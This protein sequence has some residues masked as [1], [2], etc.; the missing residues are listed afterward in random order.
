MCPAG[1]DHAEN[2][3]S[4]ESLTDGS[5]IHVGFADLKNARRWLGFPELAQADLPV[6]LEM[7]EKYAASP[8]TAVRTL[9]R[10]IEAH[11][12]ARQRLTGDPR[13][14]ATLIRLLGASEA[15]GEFLIRNPEHLD[16]ADE[17][18]QAEPQDIPAEQLRQDLLDSVGAQATDHL[19]VATVTGDDAY[20][21]LRVAY[22]RGLTR[23]ALRDL[24]A[25]SPVDQVPA[26][27]RQ[28]ADLAAAAIDAALSVSRAELLE[29]ADEQD[30][31]LLPRVSLAV[32]G[33]GK[34]GARELNYISDVDVIHVHELLDQ[35]PTTVA[36]IEAA[37]EAEADTEAT[38]TDMDQRVARSSTASPRGSVAN[39]L[40]DEERAAVL[41]AKLASGTA[42]AIMTSSSEPPLWELD[43]NL[44][45]EGKDGPL[46]R[47]VDS[48]VRYYK[49]WAKSWEFQALLKARPMAGDRE[50]GRR[51]AEAITPFVWESS[52]REGFV[53]S[54]QA[55][56]SRVTD[57]IPSEERERQI[58][59]GPGGLRDVEFT[60]QL[61]QL[62]HGRSD[63]RV[64]TQATTVSLHALSDHG[65][66]ARKD[67]EQFGQHYRWLRLLEHRIQLFRLRRTHLMPTRKP[68][69]NV[70]AVAMQPPEP[71]TRANGDAL[72]EQW[73]KV[74]RQVKGMH[75]KMFYRPLLAALS[76]TPLDGVALSDEQVRDRLTVLGY[77]DARAAQRH[78][79]ALTK[80][81]SR[82]AEILRT[83]LPVLLEWLGQ[84]VD[85]DAGLL[86]FRR[87]SEALGSSPWYLRMLRD[88]NMA[89]ERLCQIVSSSRYITDSLENQPEAVAWLGR[90]AE[91]E[92]HEFAHLWEEIQAQ[93]DRHRGADEAIRMIRVLRRREVLRVALADAC[94]LLD[95]DRV[96]AALSD[97]DRATVLGALHVAERE[98]YIREEQGCLAD[99]LVVA[100]GR[101]GGREIGYGS[102]ADVMF[103][104]MPC[105]GEHSHGHPEMDHGPVPAGQEA[106]AAD[107][108]ERT[109]QQCAADQAQSVVQRLIQLL[110]APCTPVIV[111]ERY[112]EID[113]D[114]RPEGKQGAM[115]RSVDSYREYY[116]RWAE[117]W[118]FQA[119]TRALPMAGSDAVA[120]HFLEVI[121]PHRYPAEFSD[122][123]LQ[124]IR[125]MKAR[126]ENER[127]PRGADP[128]RHLKLGRGSLSDVEWL[129][130]TLQ[131]QHAHD[132][133]SLRTTST[134]RTLQAAVEE[135]LLEEADAQALSRAWRL[136][137]QI[138]NYNVLRT[139]RSSDVLP[140]A[141]LDMEAVAR[142]CGYPSGH[143]EALEDDYLKITRHA[144]SVFERVFYGR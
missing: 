53:E 89:A 79:E 22:R 67:A 43:A 58:K 23:I 98:L 69:L 119:L 27:G 50:L 9:V 133:P 29:S 82:R 87:I 73:R 48:H 26:V 65:Y 31:D 15:L 103:A 71:V 36:Q 64:R 136:C 1:P 125:R 115:V 75:E 10:L 106:V 24:G 112:L 129:A 66:I 132:H 123:Q 51:Y 68:E 91:L 127:L 19:P 30:S 86:G 34:C 122:R 135:N 137:T 47:T 12:R 61:M 42:R 33:M 55:M 144:R 38:G 101:Q 18:L 60:V 121:D 102:D 124:D 107:D 70:I 130:Q 131:L 54:V 85:A 2:N 21:A 72:V 7:L 77:R 13:S 37:A 5:L 41:A 92:P 126:V 76:H 59:L 110:K 94:G 83:L 40:D 32:I 100:M 93:M 108:S 56:R 97:V 11:P 74:Q 96:V 52:Q 46:S 6:L 81:V 143:A 80:G 62:V 114:L 139:G 84:G 44:R 4:V 138:R 90:D 140:K 88:S 3:T 116:G 25:M 57:N 120:R 14:A 39:S 134:L 16:L 128:N 95:V 113:N 78:L 63:D 49:K 8:D 111:A 117:T 104:Y 45:P 17:P 20:R 142:W 141:G 28:L 105:T 118:E 35:A 109:A 99:V